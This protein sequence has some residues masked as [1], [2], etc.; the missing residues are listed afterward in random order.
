MENIIQFILVAVFILLFM[1]FRVS[2]YLF[3]D[4]LLN[5]GRFSFYI[6]SKKKKSHFYIKNSS[7]FIRKKNKS[8]TEVNLKAYDPNF[9]FYNEFQKSLLK[10]IILKK[11]QI[12]FKIGL[13]NNVFLTSMLSGFLQ[14]ILAGTYGYLCTKSKERHTITSIETD[15]KEETFTVLVGGRI[16]VSIITLVLSMIEAYFKKYK[17]GK[18]EVEYGK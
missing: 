6:F 13:K 10:R 7:V 5:D 17:K 4:L 9:I 2:I 16:Y 8:L 18:V 3:Y 14:I 11:F 1:P 12:S 15:F